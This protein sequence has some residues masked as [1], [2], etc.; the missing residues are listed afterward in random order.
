[1]CHF[2]TWQESTPRWVNTTKRSPYSKARCRIA[3][4]GCCPCISNTHLIRCAVR[5]GSSA[6]Y[7]RSALR[8]CSHVK[9]RRKRSAHTSVLAVAK[10]SSHFG[11][12]AAI[13]ELLPLLL[14]G[15][16]FV[17]ADE[18][19]YSIPRRRKRQP[20]LHPWQPI[21]LWH[22]SHRTRRSVRSLLTLLACR[23]LRDAYSR[24][25]RHPLPNGKFRA[26][27]SSPSDIRQTGQ[28]TPVLCSRL[29]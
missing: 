14:V 23:S 24:I 9:Q 16:Y 25:A 21:S 27:T 7:G 8:A 5:R 12:E 18:I 17:T 15:L 28:H 29:A 19:P 3:T 26:V 4:E 10:S 11:R 13:R 6:S 1:M 2:S 22:G 20:A